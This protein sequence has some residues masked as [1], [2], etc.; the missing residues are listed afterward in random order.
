MIGRKVDAS[1][2]K[3]YLADKFKKPIKRRDEGIF[4]VLFPIENDERCFHCHGTVAKLNGILAVDVSMAQT[5]TKVG[6]LSKTM[7]LWA[8]GSDRHARHLPVP[9]PDPLRDEPHPGP[10]HD[11]GTG[12]ERTGSPG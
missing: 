5:E 7:L 11:H 9:V 2:Q 8:L 12:R 1:T 4:S 3:W 10:H 6:E